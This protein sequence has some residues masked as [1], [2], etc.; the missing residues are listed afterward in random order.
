MRQT[1]QFMREMMIGLVIWSI[2]IAL[3]LVV[4]TRNYIVM[5]IGVLFGSLTAA[6][7][8]WHM[9]YHLDIAL[10]LD[11]KN[12]KKHTRFAMGQRFFIMAAVL[13]IAVIFPKYIHPLGAVFGLFGMKMTAYIYPAL[14]GCLHRN[15]KK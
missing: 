10:D 3:V 15:K 7:L 5:P 1:K 12:A 4:I 13:A 2:L 11:E 14:H 8:L 9:H 6:G